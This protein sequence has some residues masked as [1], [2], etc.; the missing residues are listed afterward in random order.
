MAQGDIER[1]KACRSAGAAM[2]KLLAVFPEKE[3]LKLKALV[4]AS[5]AVYQGTDCE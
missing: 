3:R 1:S 4:L 2:N 5:M